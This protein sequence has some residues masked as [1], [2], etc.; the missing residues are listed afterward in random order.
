MDLIKIF[1]L[2]ILCSSL[3][4]C[5]TGVSVATSGA[6]AVYKRNGLQKS[7]NDFSI[8]TEGQRELYTLTDRYQDTKLNIVVFN[9]QVLLTGQVPDQTKRAEIDNIFKNIDGVKRV[10]NFT[11]ISPAT[12][13]LTSVGD[14][15]VTAKVKAKL[16]AS[17]DIDPSRIKVTTENGTVYLLGIVEPDEAEA[18]VELARTTDGVQRV[19]KAFYYMRISKV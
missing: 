18:A 8:K 3:I 11:T 12:S 6:Q 15:W 5:S 17:N 13:T 2:A 16:I 14:A 7:F 4:S 10:Y 9:G 19:V 1:C